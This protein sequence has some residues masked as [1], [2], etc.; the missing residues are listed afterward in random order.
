MVGMKLIILHK[1]K[2]EHMEDIDQNGLK[3]I[4]TCMLIKE[5]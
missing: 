3:M 2:L 4:N 5:S 1:K